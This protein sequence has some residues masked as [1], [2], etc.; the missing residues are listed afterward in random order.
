MGLR[1]ST[2]QP[3]LPCFSP[4][5]ESCCFSN[6]FYNL[7]STW[8]RRC[9]QG[10]VSPAVSQVSLR[11]GAVVVVLLCSSCQLRPSAAPDTEPEAAAASTDTTTPLSSQHSPFKARSDH[12]KYQKYFVAICS[13]TLLALTPVNRPGKPLNS[14]NN[15]TDTVLPCSWGRAKATGQLLEAQGLSKRQTINGISY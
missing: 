12:R 6:S 14:G 1:N 2:L 10:S 4:Y 11:S 9:S 13:C 7:S 5:E 15:C 8:G 3:F